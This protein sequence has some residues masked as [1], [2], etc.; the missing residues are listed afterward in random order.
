MV[1]D[2]A[3]S[4]VWMALVE[5]EQDADNSQHPQPCSS[6][7]LL[8]SHPLLPLGTAAPPLHPLLHLSRFVLSRKHLPQNTSV[9]FELKVVTVF[10]VQSSLAKT[11]PAWIE[12]NS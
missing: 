3:S 8:S 10:Q 5:E 6:A 4:A 1:E 9:P 2:G 12:K 7:H 11:G